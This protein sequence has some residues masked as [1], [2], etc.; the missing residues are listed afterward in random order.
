M[1]DKITY[2]TAKNSGC[3]PCEEIGKLIEA[4]KFQTP[5]GELDYVDITTDEGFQRFYDEVLSKEDSGVPSAYINGQR[6]RILIED[7]V[8]KF[9]CP[10]NQPSS[11]DEKASPGETDASHDASL[12]SPPGD[13]PGPQ[14]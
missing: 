12:S 9:D 4:G 8:V 14:L 10:S 2:Y 5:N 6:C 3:Q 7:G 1:A 13:S 11:P